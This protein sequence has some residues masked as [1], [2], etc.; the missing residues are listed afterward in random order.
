VPLEACAPLII[1]VAAWP[2]HKLT[3][4]VNRLSVKE[5]LPVARVDASVSAGHAG[6]AEPSIWEQIELLKTVQGVRPTG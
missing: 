2:L 4:V 5:I 1:R 6:D 3:A